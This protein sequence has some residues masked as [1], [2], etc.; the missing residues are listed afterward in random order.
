MMQLKIMQL[1]RQNNPFEV[2]QFTSQFFKELKSMVCVLQ[3][4]PLQDQNVA[5]EAIHSP[6]LF[7]LILKLP[8]FISKG[9]QRLQKFWLQETKVL[10]GGTCILSLCLKCVVLMGLYEPVILIRRNKAEMESHLKT[11]PMKKFKRLY[12][13]SQ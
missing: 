4:Q 7:L 3:T 2:I 12:H 6:P 5:L 9:L 13:K 8:L 11:R 1:D 10:L